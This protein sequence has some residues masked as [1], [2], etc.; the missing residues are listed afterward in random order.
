MKKYLFM[1]TFLVA[2]GSFFYTKVFIPKHTFQTELITQGDMKIHV[3]G[4]GNVGAKN[5]YKIGSIFGG[6]IL[7]FHVDEG[8]FV[9]KGTLLAHIDS[10]DLEAKIAELDATLK[11]MQSDI[12]S[13]KIDKKSAAIFAQYQKDIFEKNKKLFLQKAISELELKKFQTNYQT[14]DYKV[15][16]LK[17]KLDSLYAQKVQLTKSQEGLKE[18]LQRYTIVAPISGYIVKKYVT[19]YSIVNPNQPLLEIVNP[20]DVWIEAHIDTRKSGKVKIG[21]SVKITL[22][23]SD[24]IY[25]GKVVMMNPINNS[26]TNEREVDIAFDNLPLPF[27]LEEQ[28]SVSIQVDYLKEVTK[29]SSKAFDYFQNNSGVWIVDDEDKIHFKILKVL[30]QDGK[31]IA[32]KGISSGEIAAIANPKKKAFKEGM[33]IY[34]D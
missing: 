24:I 18:K 28:A 23:S 1:A 26:V 16:S 11:K 6:K 29:I 34:H 7:D 4:I 27:F 3:S 8:D 30:A 13:L 2:A 19:N 17:N 22:R 5:I 32:V 12:A 9:K 14:A 31:F 20:K 33:K 25:D 21:D 15:I 10:V